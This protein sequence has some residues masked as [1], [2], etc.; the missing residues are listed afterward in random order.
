MGGAR[1]VQGAATH[2][3]IVAADGNAG[4]KCELA[5][6]TPPMHELNQWLREIAAGKRGSPNRLIRKISRQD[7]QS[8]GP[9]FESPTNPD[10]HL[11]ASLSDFFSQSGKIERAAQGATDARW[12]SAAAR[13]VDWACGDHAATSA[14]AVQMSP[15]D[16]ER[17]SARLSIR[18]TEHPQR[19]RAG[20]PRHLPPLIQPGQRAFQS[21]QYIKPLRGIV[22]HHPQ[23]GECRASDGALDRCIGHR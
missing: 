21:G 17:T 20:T 1:R 18:K 23:A 7:S 15:F 11:G 13:A 3:W 8:E 6:G 4:Y 16:P 10:Q 5:R 9:K 19:G 12:Q 14:V 22:G 2:A